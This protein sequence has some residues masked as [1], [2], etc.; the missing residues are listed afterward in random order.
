MEPTHLETRVHVTSAA[1]GD[2]YRPLRSAPLHESDRAVP[3]RI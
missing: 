3:R 1:V 2:C